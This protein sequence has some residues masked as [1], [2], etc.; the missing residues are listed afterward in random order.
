MEKVAYSPVGTKSSE[1]IRQNF[2]A[3]LQIYETSR[4]S[5]CLIGKSGVLIAHV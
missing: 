1:L 5:Q 4:G 2:P 3:S